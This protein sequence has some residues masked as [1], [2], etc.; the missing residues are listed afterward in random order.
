MLM[1]LGAV[2][3]AFGLFFVM[4]QA[5]K[6]PLLSTSKAVM[7]SAKTRKPLMKTIETAMLDISIHLGKLIRMD[8]YKRARMEITL[9]AADIP[10]TPEVYTA[11][12]FVKAGAVM[13]LA[14]P[15][16]FVFPALIVLVAIMAVAIFFKEIGRA[17]ELMKTR[18]EAI[19]SEL[20]RFVSTVSQELKNSR[21]VLSILENYKKTA[22]SGFANELDVT[23][24]DMR[25]SGYEAALTRFESR[26]NSAQLSDVVR[27]LISVLRGDDSAVYFQMLSHDFKLIELQNLKKRAQKV[28]PK[29]RRFSFAMLMVFLATYFVVMGMQMMDSLGTIL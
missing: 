16:L 20:P 21:D 27:G 13:L 26:I 5:L 29:I 12:A 1:I 4:A 11:N 24:A 9:K 17:D 28:P 8:K 6:I 22:N 15:C 7:N 14:I 25:S 3:L 2:F 19:E 18:R 10:M 23:C